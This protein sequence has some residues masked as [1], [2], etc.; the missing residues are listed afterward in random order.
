MSK[1]V[2]LPEPTTVYRLKA[3]TPVMDHLT[4]KYELGLKLPPVFARGYR[5]FLVECGP[6]GLTGRAS[7]CKISG[8]DGDLTLL[9]RT[10]SW[11]R[12]K[13]DDDLSFLG[14]TITPSDYP[15]VTAKAIPSDV[16]L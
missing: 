3:S 7:L 8:Y 13:L 4:G 15:M 5:L 14:F 1:T 12:D 10:W 9:T 6:S 16:S 11:S 2:E